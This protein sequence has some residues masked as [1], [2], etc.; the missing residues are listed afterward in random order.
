MVDAD[1]TLI[2]SVNSKKEPRGLSPSG[3]KEAGKAN[4]LS[5][6]DFQV[7][8]LES[9]F[10]AQPA[11]LQQGRFRTDGIR[12]RTLSLKRFH[13]LNRFADHMGNQFDPRKIPGRKTTDSAPVS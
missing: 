12:T 2:R 6:P 4:Y 13:L 10:P 7:E 3:P 11:R 8:G 9:P 1:R 5:G